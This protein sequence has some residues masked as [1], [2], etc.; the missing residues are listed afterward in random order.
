MTQY[1]IRTIEH[2]G[3]TFTDVITVRDNKRYQVVEAE[4]KE[5][6]ERKFNE[7]KDSE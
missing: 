2:K 7:R 5:E 3:E 1:L 6:A 4:S